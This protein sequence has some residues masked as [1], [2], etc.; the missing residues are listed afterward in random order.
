MNFQQKIEE[1]WSN[2]GPE[3]LEI[4]KLDV[5]EIYGS[6]AEL[7]AQCYLTISDIK[8]YEINNQ[9]IIIFNEYDYLNAFLKEKFKYNLDEKWIEL[10][11][12]LGRIY[13]LK[14][15]ENINYGD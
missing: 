8:F 3:L 1:V 5:F 9:L 12:T 14:F 10:Y 13:K 11:S 15:Q 6:R 7:I 4:C 2:F